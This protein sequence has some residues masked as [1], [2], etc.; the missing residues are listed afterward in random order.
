[1]KKIVNSKIQKQIDALIFRIEKT[2]KHQ[3]VDN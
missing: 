3:A 2:G 1:M